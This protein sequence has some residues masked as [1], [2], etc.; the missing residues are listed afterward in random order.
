MH[1][2]SSLSDVQKLRYLH[3]QLQHDPA[4]VVAGFPLT[5]IN[6]EHSVTLLQQRYG[7]P[8][9]LVNAHMNALLEIHNPMNS[10]SALQLF[11]DSV[12]SHT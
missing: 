2:N 3:A 7:Q 8:H 6:Y 4:R 12:E 5:G 1:N 11:Y 10:S 9:K